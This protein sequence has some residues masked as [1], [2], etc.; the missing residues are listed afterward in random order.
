MEIE[1]KMVIFIPFHGT[2]FSGKNVVP[3]RSGHFSIGTSSVPFQQKLE[4][5]PELGTMNGVPV[6]D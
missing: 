4:L 6:H 5:V 2:D 3:F 1:E